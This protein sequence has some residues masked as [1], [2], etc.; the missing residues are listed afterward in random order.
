MGYIK[1]IDNNTF[2]RNRR[3]KKGK[4]GTYV[5]IGFLDWVR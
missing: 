2:H 3:A 5:R 1:V 4:K